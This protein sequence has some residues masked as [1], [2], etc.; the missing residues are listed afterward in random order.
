[1]SFWTNM[2]GGVTNHTSPNDPKFEEYNSRL[3][4]FDP[5]LG[6]AGKWGKQLMK[7]FGRGDD[8]SSYGEFN[9]IRQQGA[10]N[11]RELEDSYGTGG[12][13]LLAQTGSDQAPLLQRMKE[14]ALDR[15]R[16][17][18]GM[19]LVGASTDLQRQATG[20]FE[21]ARQFRAGQELQGLGQAANNQLGYAQYLNRPI[22]KKGWLNQIA[23][24]GVK[25]AS[26]Y[27]GFNSPK[28]A[29]G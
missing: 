23:D 8:V 10:A 27:S 17:R 4:N 18:E 19:A 26:I 22:E 11:R 14:M 12:N 3:A 13:A 2:L 16:E 6:A 15:E 7:K 20:T 9:T 29:G 1:M 24:L 5:G 28:P 25:S 21:N